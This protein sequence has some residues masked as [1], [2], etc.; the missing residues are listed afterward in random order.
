[1]HRGG[2]IF[3][4]LLSLLLLAGL[5]A[6]GRETQT[7]VARRPAPTWTPTATMAPPPTSTPVSPTLPAP[8]PAPE[9]SPSPATTQAATPTAARRID[10]AGPEPVPTIAPLPAGQGRSPVRIIIPALGLDAPVQ[11]MGWRTVGDHTEWELPDNAAGHHIDSAFP[12][13]SGNVVISGH[14]NIGGS[15]FAQVSRIGESGVAFGLGDEIILEDEA[16]RRFVYRVTGWR[17]IPE[18]DASPADR[19]ENASYLLPTDS[20]QLTLITCWPADS[21]THRVIIMAALTEIRTA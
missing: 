6:C 9:A 18:R 15:V 1:M 19:Q 7:P 13:E 17:R 3:L 10:A 14:H 2:S 12:G 5:T 8:P 21:N 16:A 11:P 4:A 20:P